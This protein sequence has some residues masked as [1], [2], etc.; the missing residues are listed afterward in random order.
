VLAYISWRFVLQWSSQMDGTFQDK[1]PSISE[2]EMHE[3]QTGY[4]GMISAPT[5]ECLLALYNAWQIK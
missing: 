1:I 2:R 4:G 3:S 5:A